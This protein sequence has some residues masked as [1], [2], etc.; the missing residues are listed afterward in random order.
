VRIACARC[1]AESVRRQK[2]GGQSFYKQ[3]RTLAG[4]LQMPHEAICVRRVAVQQV[5]RRKLF[6]MPI[7]CLLNGY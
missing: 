5:S 4:R 6:G 1:V 7:K 3:F 2:S